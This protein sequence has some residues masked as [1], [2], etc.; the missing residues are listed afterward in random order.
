MEYLSKNVGRRIVKRREQ[1]NIQQ[2]ELAKL[3][4]ISNNHLCEIEQ[5]NHNPSLEL[6]VRICDKLD[7]NPDYF[8]LGNILV[9]HVPKRVSE[10]ME[11]CSEEDVDLIIS[12]IEHLIRIRKEEENK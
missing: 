10:A 11:L 8:L 5:G 12:I 7:V 1:K 2:K 9:K 3:L 4:G 6:F